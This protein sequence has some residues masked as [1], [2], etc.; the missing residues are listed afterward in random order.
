MIR[1]LMDNAIK[2]GRNGKIIKF[3]ITDEHGA[4][5]IKVNDYG[6]GIDN[7]N[8]QMI[9]ERFYRGDKS[10]ATKDGGMGLGLAISDEIIKLHGGKIDVES[11]LGNGTLFI[12]S[13]PKKTLIE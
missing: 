9:F 10:R 3:S 13:L 1:N 8:L 7:E 5:C 11:S 12:V 6:P 4:M 2:Y